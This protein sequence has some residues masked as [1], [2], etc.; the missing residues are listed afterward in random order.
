MWLYYT[1]PKENI[2]NIDALIPSGFELRIIHPHTNSIHDVL[3]NLFS[4]G[5][6]REYQLVDTSNRLTVS[7]AQVMPKIVIFRFMKSGGIHIG[8]CHTLPA[9]RGRNFYPTLL[10]KIVED[11][12]MKIRD[13]Y[14]FCDEN[15]SASIRGIEKAGFKCFAKGV[16]NKFGI[17]VIKEY[18]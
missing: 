3:W 8:P 1:Y 13:F 9:Y 14:I 4:F 11:Y 7:K 17:Y 12:R 6:Y 10:K 5:K 16:K 15:N 2:N 18:I